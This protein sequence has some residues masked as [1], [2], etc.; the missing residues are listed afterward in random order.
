MIVFYLL[1]NVSYFAVLGPAGILES[2]A[3][4]VVRIQTDSRIGRQAGRQA[5]QAQTDR[6]T[7]RQI[8]RQTNGQE[9][10]KRNRQCRQSGRR[11]DI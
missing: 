5:R 4:A 7:D 11:T 1:V 6:Q 9:D 10:R 3:V 2:E 8:N